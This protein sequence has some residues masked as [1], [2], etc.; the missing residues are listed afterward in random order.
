[1]TESLY[2]Q[3]FRNISVR[4]DTSNRVLITASSD[5]LRP[6][7]RAAGRVARTA[8]LHAPLEARGIEVTLLDGTTRQAR[9]EFF[10]TDA[11]RRYFEGRA[12]LDELKA[13]TKIEWINPAAHVRNPFERFDDLSPEAKPQVL[14]AL[15]PDTFSV[16]RVANDYVGAAEAATKTDWLRGAAIGAG[17]V[18]S[19]SVFDRRLNRYAEDHANS[20][21]LTNGVRLGDAIPWIA[22]AGA[23]LAAIDGSDPRRSRTGYAALE[24]GAAGFALATGLKYVAGRARPNAGLGARAFNPGSS[25]D[26]LHSLPSRHTVVAWAVATPFALEYDMPWLYAIAGLTN[27]ARVGSREHWLSDTVASSLIGYGLGR[28]FWTSAREQSKR[29]PKLYFDGTGLGMLWDW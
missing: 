17:L 22:L 16:S 4:Y 7:G 21:W 23:G 9:Y 18:L 27:A 5:Q 8:L 13:N 26:S 29:E 3:G 12:G 11:L 1:L 10:N 25:E 2:S 15:V 14:T 6:I 20:S 24:A 28:I 19:A